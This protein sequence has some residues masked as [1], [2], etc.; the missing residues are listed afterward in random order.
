LINGERRKI[1]DYFEKREI[2]NQRV[3]ELPFQLFELKDRDG[4]YSCLIDV[5]FFVFIQEN[6]EYELFRYVQLVDSNN[7][8]K[9]VNN[10]IKQV[11]NEKFN[12]LKILNDV[13]VFIDRFYFKYKEALKLYNKVLDI[14]IIS[15][16]KD[17]FEV[18]TIYNNIANTYS[19][20]NEIE[21]SILYHKKAIEIL[22]NY[23]L[24][25][26]ILNRTLKENGNPLLARTYHNIAISYT[27]QKKYQ[28]ALKYLQNALDISEFYWGINHSFTY[29]I[30]IAFARVYEDLEEYESAYNYNQKALKIIAK[31]YGLKHPD[32]A[33]VY[34]SIAVILGKANSD[35]E[36]I[37]SIYKA[38]LNI[39]L[40]VFGELHPSVSL[41]YKNLSDYYFSIGDYDN[42]LP[43]FKKIISIDKK[44][45]N[46][47]DINMGDNYFKLSTFYLK[48]EDYLESYVYMKQALDV[49]IFNDNAS[50]KIMMTKIS[51]SILEKELDS[52]AVKYKNLAEKYYANQK[53]DKSLLF[54]DKLLNISKQYLGENHYNTAMLYNNK[55]VIY[56]LLEKYEQAIYYHKLGIKIFKTLFKEDN[57][58]IGSSYHNLAVSYYKNKNYTNAYKYIKLALQIRVKCLPVD[59]VHI[60]NSEKVFVQIIEEINKE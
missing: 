5:E 60:F 45:F 26:D 53:Y 56:E 2:D 29:N 9:T 55:A 14:T 43:L 23:S 8:N 7:D 34:N 11:I 10:L 22:K 27:K 58:D 35:K 20:M 39:N 49:Y 52:L 44:I 40:I 6:N 42:A 36:T 21:N 17:H 19:A 3:R 18:S 31:M 54:Y 46:K 37:I 41:I 24:S 33:R 47:I 15:F 48:Q 38:A 50:E 16:G 28:K 13:T 4:L 12:D 30:Y 59:D 51:L 1:A 32:I 57:A 25:S